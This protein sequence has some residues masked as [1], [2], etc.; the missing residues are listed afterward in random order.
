MGGCA[1]APVLLSHRVSTSC[2]QNL[3]TSGRNVGIHA[4]IIGT[5][6]SMTVQYVVYTPSHV[7]SC[8]NAVTFSSGKRMIETRQTL[9]QSVHHHH[10]TTRVDTHKNPS[11]KTTPNHTLSL[12][13]S[14]L[15]TAH[16]T[17][18]GR[19]KIATSSAKFPAASA[20]HFSSRGMQCLSDEKSQ[21]ACTGMQKKMLLAVSQRP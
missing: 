14:V 1:E 17:G 20:H 10:T 11:A 3:A 19:Q 8:E 16:T 2:G 13:G 21:K 4:M 6:I 7:G 9:P 5:L 18:S 12:P 15:I